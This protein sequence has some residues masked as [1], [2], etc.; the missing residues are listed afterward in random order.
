ERFGV[1]LT[2]ERREAFLHCWSVVG[3]LMGIL[4]ELLP[5]SVDEAE[6]LFLAIQARQK[7]A[8]EEGRTLTR[9]QERFVEDSLRRQGI[10]GRFV[11]PRLTRMLIRELTPIEIAHLLD[12]RP[13]AWWEGLLSYFAFRAIDRVIDKA[14]GATRRS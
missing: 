8:T 3:L 5:S 11:A 2:E 13:P 7:A 10:G 12:V 4:P 1:E 9:A 6:R 14:E